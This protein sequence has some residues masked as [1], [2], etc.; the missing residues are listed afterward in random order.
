MVSSKQCRRCRRSLPLG[1]FHLNRRQKDGHHYYCKPCK[2][3][4]AG[5]H[6]VRHRTAVKG[7]VHR[8]R[9]TTAGKRS[10][11]ATYK[12]M[13][14]LYPE[15]YR[16]RTVLNNALVRGQ[17]SRPLQCSQC[18]IVGRRIVAHHPD[19]SKPLDVVWC[20]DPC[21]HTLDF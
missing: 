18:G 4:A 1:Q 5:E 6:Y 21:H 17:L 12:R 2:R 19:Y 8:W 11:A 10:I 7:R 3:D 13:K 14:E 15:K 16:A 9:Q 20:C